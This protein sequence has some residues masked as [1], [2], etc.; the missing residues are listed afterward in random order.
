MPRSVEK[1]TKRMQDSTVVASRRCCPAPVYGAQICRDDYWCSL[2]SMNVKS[3]SLHIV[4]VVILKITVFFI[5]ILGRQ[6]RASSAGLII[7]LW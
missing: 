3:A 1:Q 7:L 5:A 4:V 6:L 2:I